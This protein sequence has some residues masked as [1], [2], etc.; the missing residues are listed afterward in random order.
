M[1]TEMLE[2]YRTG[3]TMLAIAQ[4][5][6]VGLSDVREVLN[7]PGLRSA[8]ELGNRKLCGR[9]HTAKPPADGRAKR[10]CRKAHCRW[11]RDGAC[12][13]VLPRCLHSL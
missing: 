11:R 5:H 3:S 8:Y 2:E 6:G 1:N 9:I 10:Q 7:D 12:I 4:R 13:C